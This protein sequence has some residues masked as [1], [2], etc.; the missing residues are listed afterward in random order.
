MDYATSDGTAQAGADYTAASGT[1]SFQAGEPSGTTEVSV[2]DDAH[3]EGEETLT[4]TLLPA[5]LLARFSRE[6]RGGTLSLWSRS[7]RSHF[8][9]LEDA[10]SLNGD[11]RTTLSAA[12]WARGPL[13]RTRSRPSA[14]W[15]APG[16]WGGGGVCGHVVG[17]GGPGREGLPVGD[18]RLRVLELGPVHFEA[19]CGRRRACRMHRMSPRNSRENVS[20]PW[21]SDG[22]EPANLSANFGA[23]KGSLGRASDRW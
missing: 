9:G 7:S 4:L 12:D 21:L 20:A 14:P 5:V 16:S 10:L 18:D 2:L 19:A 3:Y 13:T 1:L 15:P 23:R 8:S 22:R 17:G 11:V 6:S